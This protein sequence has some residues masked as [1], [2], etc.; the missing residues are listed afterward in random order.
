MACCGLAR[1][2]LNILKY[3]HMNRI[4]PGQSE[5]V[6]KHIKN[7]SRNCHSG[8]AARG[9]EGPKGMHFNGFALTIKLVLVSVLG[10]CTRALSMS[11][12]SSG[13][14]IVRFHSTIE[15]YYEHIVPGQARI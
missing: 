5:F 9:A 14:E 11:M 8:R 3:F 4:E 1:R 10:G 6:K 7:S 12:M 2:L 15:E 13:S